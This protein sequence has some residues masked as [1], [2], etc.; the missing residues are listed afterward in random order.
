MSQSY[1]IKQSEV[2]QH[3][4][5]MYVKQGNRCALCR[6]P[7]SEAEQA[8]DHC[9]KTGV[10]RGTLH[11]GCNAMLGHIENNLPRHKLTNTAKLSAFLR[12]IIPYLHMVDQS[13]PLHHTFR[14]EEEKRLKRNAKAR[15][16]RAAKKESP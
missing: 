1:R 3:R 11:R 6:L 16:A 4:H 7:I 14:T 5:D 12:N 13:A 8:L 9:H 2:K 15:K 10:L